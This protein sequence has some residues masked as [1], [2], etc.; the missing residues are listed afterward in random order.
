MVSKEEGKALLGIARRAIEASLTQE[1]FLLSPEEKERFSDPSGVFVTLHKHGKLRG[2][3]GYPTA[4]M[5]LHD[6]IVSA[7]KSAAFQ[8]PRFQPVTHEEL[9]RIDV[10]VSVLSQPERIL[11][12]TPEEIIKQVKVG[13]HGLIIKNDGFSGLLLPQVAKEYGWAA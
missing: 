5:P 9:P 12:Q 6:A 11:A 3:I 8:D 10:E 7:A 13:K 1:E 4:M 2:C